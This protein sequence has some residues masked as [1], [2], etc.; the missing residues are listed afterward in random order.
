[1][2]WSLPLGRGFGVALRLRITFLLLLGW[3]G[4]EA[5]VAGGPS[6]AKWELLRVCLIFLC[7]ILHEL[8]HS[9]VAQR[10]GVEV[11]SITLLP[12]GG[13][14]ALRNIPENPWHE[15]AI[16]VAGPMVNAAIAAVLLPIAGLPAMQDFVHIPQD[17]G[18]L[19]R[20]LTGE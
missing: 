11:K 18:G 20:A 10:L 5:F 15:I 2:R 9:V 4:Y 14:A 7:I 12:I 17:F 16:T 6:A 3:V 8:G 13:V 19:L 1:M